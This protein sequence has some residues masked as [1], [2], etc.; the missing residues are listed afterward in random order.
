MPAR[1]NKAALVN[2]LR[3]ESKALN[4][5]N[6]PPLPAPE[7][8]IKPLEHAYLTVVETVYHQ[9]A[10]GQPISVNGNWG[11]QLTTDSQPYLRRLKVGPDW[12]TLDLGWLGED[13][14]GVGLLVLVNTE[15]QF[16]AVNPTAVEKAATGARVVE[17]AVEA[18]PNPNTFETQIV[19]FAELSPGESLR[20]KPLDPR[21]LKI[22]CRVGEAKVSLSLFPR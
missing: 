1:P 6:G 21:I 2:R 20:Y 14:E 9:P 11:R 15:G 7:E 18:A 12:Q 8:T 17:L 10:G 16:L 13:G 4:A 3:Q 22:R 19:P 5:R